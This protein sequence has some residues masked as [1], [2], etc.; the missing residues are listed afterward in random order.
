MTERITGVIDRLSDAEDYN[1]IAWILEAPVENIALSAVDDTMKTNADFQ[2]EAGLESS[3]T[4][5]TEPSGNWPCDWCQGLEGTYSIEDYPSELFMHHERCRCVIEWDNKQ[6]GTY[7]VLRAVDTEPYWKK[8]DPAEI[9]GRKNFVGVNTNPAEIVAQRLEQAGE[10][11][12]EMEKS[13]SAFAK[14]YGH[15]KTEHSMMTDPD[16]NITWTSKKGRGSADHVTIPRGELIP[17]YSNVHNHPQPGTFSPGDVLIQEQYGTKHCR[18][19]DIDGNV[20]TLT[21]PNPVPVDRDKCEFYF[22]YSDAVKKHENDVIDEMR[23][24]REQLQGLGLSREEVTKRY[25]AWLDNPENQS[26]WRHVEWLKE[27]APKFG[28]SFN[29]GKY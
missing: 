5:Y 19:Y 21:N 15:A 18:V 14:K 26:R 1:S 10:I 8:I 4:R 28:W 29:L 3:V 9:E 12:Q 7:D 25:K 11:P 24:Y 2:R 17:G 20:Y 27:N 6:T 23:E 16:G 22:A 13:F